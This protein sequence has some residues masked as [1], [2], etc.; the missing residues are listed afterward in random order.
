MNIMALV[1]YKNI[2]LREMPKIMK[3][4]YFM[5]EQYR[6]NATICAWPLTPG[7][8]EKLVLSP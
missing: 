4:V 5:Q 6:G 1:V 8:S 7:A 2:Y 3:K